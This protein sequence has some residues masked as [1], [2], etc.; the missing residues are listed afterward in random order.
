MVLGGWDWRGFLGGR[1]LIRVRGLCVAGF[2]VKFLIFGRGVQDLQSP[3]ELGAEAG[4]V[5]V[6][7]LEGAAIVYQMLVGD[8]GAGV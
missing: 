4:F 5:A 6:E 3:A 8:G 2:M 7:A 1:I